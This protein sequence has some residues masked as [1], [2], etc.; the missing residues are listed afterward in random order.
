M[1]HS[2]EV[3]QSVSLMNIVYNTERKK[4]FLLHD[5]DQKSEQMVDVLNWY[6]FQ[7]L[8]KRITLYNNFLTL[9]R[10]H[11]LLIFVTTFLTFWFSCA[12]NKILT[13]SC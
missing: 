8:P 4:C 3:V 7:K 12:H 2:K 5:I 10:L 13:R 6:F 9:T 11:F 1:K